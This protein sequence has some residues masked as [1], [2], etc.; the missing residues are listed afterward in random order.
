MD[1]RIPDDISH[2]RPTPARVDRWVAGLAGVRADVLPS[3]RRRR[4]LHTGSCTRSLVALDY[5]A[6]NF[7]KIHRTLR[8]TPAMA[9]GVT[10]QLWHVADLVAPWG[11]CE[12][13]EERRDGTRKRMINP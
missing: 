3:R 7:I 10:D 5:F 11:A 13:G 9:A 2:A 12:R 1:L 6:Y 8:A 4:G